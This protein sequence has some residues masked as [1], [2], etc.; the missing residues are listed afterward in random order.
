MVPPHVLLEVDGGVNEETIGDC[1]EAG[2]QLLVVGSAIFKHA[3]YTQAMRR[4]SSLM[5]PQ[6]RVTR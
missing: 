3:D 4:L 1:V 6:A 2:A 5:E